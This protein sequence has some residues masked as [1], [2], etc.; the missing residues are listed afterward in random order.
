M[1]TQR[2]RSTA[3]KVFRTLSD[4]NPDSMKEIFYP[5][6]N[7]THRKGNL[8][9]HT[10]NT[11]KFGNRSL[12]ESGRTYET[13]Y[14]KTIEPTKSFIEFESL[15]NFNMTPENTNLQNFAVSFDLEDLIHKATCFKALPSCIDLIITNRKS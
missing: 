4:L 3:Y 8:Y 13:H 14:L 1:Q 7:L 15:H 2:L 6:P 12:G 11:I 10:R 9:V 5:F